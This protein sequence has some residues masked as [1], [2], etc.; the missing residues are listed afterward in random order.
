MTASDRP[1]PHPWLRI[2]LPFASG[3]FVSYLYR[4]VNAIL[5]PNLVAELHLGAADLGLLTSVYFLAFAL[6]QL[7]LGILLDH[8]GPRRVQAALLL[9]AALGAGVF[10][11]S[12]G[13]GGLIVGRAL[14]GLGVSACLMA[15]FKAFVLWFPVD[16]LPAVNGWALA[17]G[18]LGAL[19]AT[20]PVEAALGVTTWRGVFAGLAVVTL[21]VAGL[22]FAV[23]PERQQHGA[24][25]TLGEQLRSLGAVFRDPRFWQ[26]APLTMFSQAAFMAIQGLWAGPWL[27]DTAGLPRH[28]VANHLFVLA[29]AMAA[30]FL[31]LGNLA[32][33][34]ARRGIPVVAVAKAGM[35]AFMAVQLV[36]VLGYAGAPLLT[37]VLFGF[38]GTAG[39]LS[40]AL[41]AERFP[42][43][44]AGRVNSALNFL[45]F[46]FSFLA[47][48]AI[49]AVLDRW[50]SG[51]DRYDPAGYSV[52]FGILLVLQALS[53]GWFVRHER[54]ARRAAEPA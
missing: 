29:A 12:S 8:Y 17:S 23:V 40:Y 50:P 7:P 9:V 34:L 26:V 1:P 33:R 37:W 15:S 3:Y 46:L 11:T 52:A 13:M 38:F 48:T 4:S 54:R 27:R 51:D 20:A 35:A 45:V 53:Y 25:M 16:R 31:L 39:T 5:S 18:G 28:E 10:A 6:F 42:A 24:G 41:L 49:G 22:I 36:V 32:S 14:V 44:I 47:Q 2:V 30:G 43:R 21:A 19:A